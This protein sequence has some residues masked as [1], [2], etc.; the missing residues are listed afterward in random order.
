VPRNSHWSCPNTDKCNPQLNLHFKLSLNII[1]SSKPW[2]SQCFL[3]S[4]FSDPGFIC[5][6]HAS[7]FPP[8]LI[9]SSH[10][11]GWSKSHTTHIK[12]RIDGYNSIKFDRIGKHTISLSLYRS[13]CRSRHV[14][15]RSRQSV[16]CL[17]T[18]EVQECPS[19]AQCVFI[20]EHC[21]ASLCYLTCQ[22]SFRD[23]FPNYPVPN[24]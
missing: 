18:V 21:L 14:V 1:F 19:K 17:S 11:I 12:I 7:P 6:S 15:T 3:P 10:N 2:S 23:T 8:S 5:F 24:K 4:R 9:C 13:K 16:S 20:V 22:N